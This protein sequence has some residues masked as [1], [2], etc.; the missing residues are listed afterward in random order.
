LLRLPLVIFIALILDIDP[1]SPIKVVALTS[2]RTS[3]VLRGTEVPMP[4]L[5]PSVTVMVFTMV[6]TEIAGGRQA[7][8]RFPEVMLFAFK[9][10]MSDPS[11]MNPADARMAPATSSLADPEGA[12]PIPTLE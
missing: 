11:P 5:Q 4:T 8:G 9:F 3:R 7:A 2:P 10:V 1:A 6:F 12:A